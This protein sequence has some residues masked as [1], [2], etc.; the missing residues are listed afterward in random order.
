MVFPMLETLYI[1]SPAYLL[2]FDLP[3]LRSL[4]VEGASPLEDDDHYSLWIESIPSGIIS[5]TIEDVVLATALDL[6]LQPISFGNLATIEMSG[7]LGVDL[8]VHN[9]FFAPQLKEVKIACAEPHDECA[10]EEDVYLQ[11]V[12]TNGLLARSPII[13]FHVRSLHPLSSLLTSILDTNNPILP[14]L[15]FMD[16]TQSYS[17][18][19]YDIEDLKR[20]FSLRRSNVQLSVS[21]A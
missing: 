4:S 12:G 11:F 8:N 9:K 7:N 16:L 15:T 17:Q 1:A 2:R 6:H 14:K 5:L 3:M 18:A 19:G 21:E 20:D 10:N 13:Q